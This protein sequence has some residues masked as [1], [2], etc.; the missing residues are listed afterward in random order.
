MKNRISFNYDL[1]ANGRAKALLVV[2]EEQW[3]FEVSNQGDP[4]RELLDNMCAMILTPSHL[5]E[6]QNQFVTDWFCD[7]I[8]VR[9]TLSTPDAVKLYVRLAV[10]DDIFDEESGN[11][12]FETECSYLD[13]YCAIIKELDCFI[14]KV[15]L[16]NYKQKWHNQGFPLSSFLFLKKTLIDKG[17]WKP[18]S[19]ASQAFNDE[20]EL[21]MA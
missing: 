9:W 6:E 16:L 2:D 18:N 10:F 21:L 12:I 20:M 19:K 11:V 1:I 4:L 14:K 15:G 3:G 8:G 5:W 7:L 17:V 13:F